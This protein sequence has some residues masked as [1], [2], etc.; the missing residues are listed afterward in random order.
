MLATLHSLTSEKR[1]HKFILDVSTTDMTTLD[2]AEFTQRISSAPISVNAVRTRIF[3]PITHG[4]LFRCVAFTNG[5][6]KDKLLG[7]MR[8]IHWRSQNQSNTET[9]YSTSCSFLLKEEEKE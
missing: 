3:F 4:C 7:L 9:D 6:N 5:R 1:V 2:A 8:S